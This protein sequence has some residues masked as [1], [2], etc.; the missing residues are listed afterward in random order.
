MNERH[1]PPPA[2]SR[3]ARDNND[4]HLGRIQEHNVVIACL[5]EYGTASATGAAQHMLYS[6][7]KI[8]FVLLVGVDGIV[9]GVN[10]DIRLGDVIISSPSNWKGG[11]V[12]YDFGKETEGGKSTNRLGI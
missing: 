2:K 9:P 12:Q 1:E 4:Y 8:H 6:F 3:D 5:P 7:G 10:N 11:V